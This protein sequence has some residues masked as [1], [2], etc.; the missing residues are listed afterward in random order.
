[1][2][3]SWKTTKAFSYLTG[4]LLCVGPLSGQ[5]MQQV[6]YPDSA[7]FLEQANMIGVGVPPTR[8]NA[9]AGN[10]NRTDMAIVR[11][12][13]V[14]CTQL[15]PV[16]S[17]SDRARCFAAMQAALSTILIQ[18][19]PCSKSVRVNRDGKKE[20]WR[21]VNDTWTWAPVFSTDTAGP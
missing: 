7:F 3:E 21:L 1:M 20:C 19:G 4:A 10:V 14:V 11:V 16:D 6:Q 8:T 13:V 2:A 5:R 18:M 9:S 17:S 15:F 12:A